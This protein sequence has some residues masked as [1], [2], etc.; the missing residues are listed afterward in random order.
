MGKSDEQ[1]AGALD[2]AG[3]LSPS[4][5][6]DLR[7]DLWHY[8]NPAHL[9]ASEQTPV[10]ESTLSS[11]ISSQPPSPHLERNTES[12]A[13]PTPDENS[14]HATKPFT[15]GELVFYADRVELCGVDICSGNRSRSKRFVLELLS[16]QKRDGTFVAHSSDELEKRVRELGGKGTA[17]GLIRN[18]RDDIKQRLEVKAKIYCDR[19]QMILSGGPGNRLAEFLSV[20]RID[21]TAIKD[22][23]DMADKTD[24]PNVPDDDV[25]DVPD[26]ASVRQDWILNQLAEG[27]QLKT[28]HVVDHFQ[29]SLKTAQ[30]DLAALKDAGKIDFHGLPRTGYYRLSQVLPPIR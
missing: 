14:P 6:E 16:E 15:G 21:Q 7:I 17:N 26:H 9:S 19:M 12:R 4:A 3:M 28:K 11:D 8:G 10:V 2:E 30:R 18:L 13:T 29:V 27:S 1:I 5:C 24:V 25:R 20:Q 23:R 22:I